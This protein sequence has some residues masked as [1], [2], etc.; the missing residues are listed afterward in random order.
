VRWFRGLASHETIFPAKKPFFEG[1]EDG[2]KTLAANIAPSDQTTE[3]DHVG[4]IQPDLP[5]IL[6][7][8]PG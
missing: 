1:D 8:S 6:H 3:F 5:G 7:C 2:R 4:A